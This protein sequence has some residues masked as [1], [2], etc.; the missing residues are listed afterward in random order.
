[1]RSWDFMPD[2]R[3]GPHGAISAAFLDRDATDYRAAARIVC[4]LPYGRNT[5]RDD[6]LAVL[7]EGRGTCGTKHALLA[8]LA[9]EQGLAIDLML[10]IYAMDG[11]NT[12]GV[13]NVLRRYGLD[14]IPEAHCY[15]MY[16]TERVDVTRAAVAAESIAE[17][18][19]EQ[20]ITPHQIGEY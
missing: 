20:A 11:R 14:S 1:M 7:C 6:S 15:L 10:G 9:L 3:L 8:R 5:N 16:R 17:F 19:F 12:P 18:L 2:A 4:G 13:E